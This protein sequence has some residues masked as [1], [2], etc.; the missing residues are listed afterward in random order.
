MIIYTD[1]RTHAT[2]QTAEFRIA[3]WQEYREDGDVISDRV[4]LTIASWFASSGTQG[5]V[6]AALASTGQVD[7]EDL[8]AEIKRELDIEHDPSDVSALSALEAWVY[9]KID[10]EDE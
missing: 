7:S 6:F 8:L 3:T 4:A 9:D 5:R 10:L 1:T 2:A